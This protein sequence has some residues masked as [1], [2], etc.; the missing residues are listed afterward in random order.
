MSDQKKLSK[1]CLTGFILALLPVVLIALSRIDLLS[2]LFDPVILILSPV[3]GLILSIVGLVS[4]NRKGYRGKGFG[5]AGIVLNSIS[6]VIIGIVFLILGLFL[7]M[8]SVRPT[9]KTIPDFYSDSKI[10]SVRYYRREEDGTYL[11]YDGTRLELLSAPIGDEYPGSEEM[12][13]RLI[14]FLLVLNTRSEI[15][16]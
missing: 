9:D 3:A 2:F 5:I 15:R 7:G 11:T 14:I 6:V 10:V 1:L 8:L 4:A 13:R 16:P 12:F